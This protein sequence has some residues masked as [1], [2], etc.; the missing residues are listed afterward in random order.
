MMMSPTDLQDLPI[1]GI[2]K[3]KISRGALSAF[4][5][6][7]LARV[8]L[9]VQIPVINPDGFL[10]IQQAK[11]LHLGLFNQVLN[12]YHY[13]SPYPVFVCLFY[14]VTGNWVSAAQWL[15]VFF[16]TLTIIPLYWLLKRFF[17]DATAWI[18]VLVFALLPAYALAST[19]I[20][21]DPMFW[22][23]TATGLYFFILQLEKSGHLWLLLSSI[24]FAAGAWFRIEGSLFIMV[25]GVFLLF[26]NG[27]QRWKNLAVFLAPYLIAA[28]AGILFANFRDIDLM[29]LLK[30]ERLLS[31]PLE[32]FSRYHSIRAQLETLYDTDLVRYA[33]YFFHCVRN[34]IWLIALGALLVQ[35]A[36]TL[37]Y[38]CLVLLAVGIVDWTKRLRTDRRVVYL[39][40]LSIL[41]LALLYSQIIYNWVMTSRFLAV[42]LLP[43]FFFIGAGTERMGTLISSRFHLRYKHTHAIMC[44]IIIS[45]LL[46]KILRANFDE[47]KLVFRRIGIYIA[48]REN[49]SRLVSIGGGFTQV[50]EI[51]FFTNLPFPGA[52][53]FKRSTI[54]NPKN[55]KGVTDMLKRHLHYLVWD[56][57]N[58]EGTSIDT[59]CEDA[60]IQLNRLCEWPS[61]RLGRL[62]LYEVVR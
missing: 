19:W 30:P 46:P 29:E 6:G 52:P 53:C 9:L 51:Y 3:W 59:L 8:Y 1:P 36:E 43:A 60:G 14:R 23:F 18:T 55:K 39:W 15:N 31:R 40:T 25:S 56:Q 10:Y 37:L 11:A 16:G 4:I 21:R 2:H 32:F 7:F 17:N 27:N 26:V 5:L 22:F 48:E 47:D 24:C 49:N 28:S 41:S 61:D 13:L 38:L 20:I 45:L 42:F 57:R 62:V 50:S 35:L 33:P 12:C 34:L 58:W 54:L 44:V